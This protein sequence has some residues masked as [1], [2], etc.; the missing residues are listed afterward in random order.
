[1]HLC[2]Q[3]RQAAWRTRIAG[4]LGLPHQPCAQDLDKGVFVQTFLISTKKNY[5]E[6]LK[7][8]AYDDKELLCALGNYKNSHVEAQ[9][10]QQVMEMSRRE[11]DEFE[12]AI[13]LSLADTGRGGVGQTYLQEQREVSNFL[14]VGPISVRACDAEGA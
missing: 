14:P 2:A 8:A 6:V 5:S 10:R 3:L 9:I 12:R 1:M 4:T 7:P 11:Q 13:A